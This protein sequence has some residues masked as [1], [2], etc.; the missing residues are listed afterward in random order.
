MIA[1]NTSPAYYAATSTLTEQAYE[2]AVADK[3]VPYFST[4]PPCTVRFNNVYYTIPAN[5]VRYRIS[6]IVFTRGLNSFFIQGAGEL[7][8]ETFEEVF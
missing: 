5:S 3:A 7:T 6:D 8:V 1:D 4:T 2:Q